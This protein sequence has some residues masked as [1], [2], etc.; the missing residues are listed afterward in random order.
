MLRQKSRRQKD[1]C[2]TRIW[3][4]AADEVTE[5]AVDSTKEEV[6]EVHI[7]ARLE[8]ILIFRVSNVVSNGNIHTLAPIW[9]IFVIR[10]N[11]GEL[12]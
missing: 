5:E 11:N 3:M 7:K 8:Q 6:D 1:K 4:S 10:D 12:S 2:S 9:V